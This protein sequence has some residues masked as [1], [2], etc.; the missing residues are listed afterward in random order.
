MTEITQPLQSVY[1]SALSVNY[2]KWFLMPNLLAAVLTQFLV[3]ST[4]NTVERKMML[5]ASGPGYFVSTA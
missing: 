4:T 3:I 5:L 1:S 2:R